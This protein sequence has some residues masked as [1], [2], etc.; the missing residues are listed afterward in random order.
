MHL[1]CTLLKEQRSE[2]W[3]PPPISG[4]TLSERKGHSRC[5]GR[6]PG[7]SRSSSQSSKNN[8]RNEKSHSWNGTSHDLSNTKAT[9]LGATLGAIPGIDGNP[10]E[11]CSFAP[12]FSE[13][14][15]RE[16]GWSPRAR[17]IYPCFT[18]HFWRL[19]ETTRKIKITFRG[20][21]SLE[22]LLGFL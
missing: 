17:P 7:Y 14:L 6:V 4:K 21:K 19:F 13:R 8:F 18:W 16:L 3:E 2:A 22:R 9:I 15:F 1:V 10:H 20:S 11:R 12:S 5:S